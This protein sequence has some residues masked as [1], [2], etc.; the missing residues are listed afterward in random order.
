MADEAHAHPEDPHI[1]TP[2][3]VTVVGLVANALLAA[4]K[5]V[6]GLVWLSQA[7]L[8]DGLHSASD[9]VTD[10]AVLAG[11]RVADRPADAD[12]RYG[13]RRVN[14]LVAMFVGAA[15][16]AA[17]AWI[18]YRAIVTLREPVPGF[19]GI[20]PLV[21]AAASVPVKEGLYQLT[22]RVGRR[23]GNL[24]VVAN[25]WHHRTD[26]LTSLAATAGLAGAVF[27]G[28]DWHFLDLLTAMVLATFLATVAARIVLSA[29]SELT[30]SAPAAA[31]LA[32]IE[33][34]VA[35]TP[36]VVSYHA[37]RARKLGGKVEMDIHV[38]VDPELTV[39]DGHD[40]AET[41][42]Q[43]VMRA[44]LNV[45]QVIVHVEPPADA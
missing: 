3:G 1:L 11:L 17:G 24:A 16:L 20:V 14:T 39:R 43:R 10:V 9:L 27:G 44:D 6:A 25:A 22:R 23:T 15:L 12:H 37:F 28:A 30:D 18:G 29:A 36:G 38:Q 40:I 34:T 19:R 31:A 2:Q 42:K 35:E 4:A 8:A 45:V 21:L 33:Q 26:A 41:V 13:H 5:T 7:I 32:S